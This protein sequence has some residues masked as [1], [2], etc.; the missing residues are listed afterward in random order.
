MTAFSVRQRHTSKAG[1]LQT[2]A[3]GSM[4]HKRLDFMRVGLIENKM[5]AALVNVKRIRKLDS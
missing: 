3:C 1:S 2:L 4:A 5:R